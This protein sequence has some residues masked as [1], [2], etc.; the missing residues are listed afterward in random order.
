MINI[1]CI[2]WNLFLGLF[3]KIVIFAPKMKYNILELFQFT[4]LKLYEQRSNKIWLISLVKQMFLN[5]LC[6]SVKG[7]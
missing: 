2:S 1:H 7:K 6:I 5:I 4:G 3:S